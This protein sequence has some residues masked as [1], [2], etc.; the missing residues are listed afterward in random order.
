MTQSPTMPETI[1]ITAATMRDDN[2]DVART[3]K[4][5]GYA[6][7]I[8]PGVVPPTPEELHG[9][10]HDAVGVIA[11]S[12]TYSR[13]VM[14]AAPGLRVISRNGV[15]YDAVDLDAATDLGIVVAYVPDA[16]V[17][18][19]ADLTLGLLLAAA[20]RITMLDAGMK[21][22][23][24]RRQIAADV[25][26]TT[27][28]IVGTGRIGLAV[29]RRAQAFG[30][31]LLG[32]D[33]YPNP[34]FTEEFG[35]EYLPLDQLLEQSDYVSLHMPVLPETRGLMDAPRLARMKPSAYL[36]NAAR[37]ALVDEAA[38]LQALEAGKLAGAALDVF[39]TEPPLPDSPA[40]KLARHPNVVATPHVASY[41]PVTAARMGQ[42]AMEN[43]LTALG[44]ERPAY[45]ANPDVYSRRL[46][47]R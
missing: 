27:L 31:R 22:G 23:E 29:A 1:A 44:G 40:A 12:D 3:L 30:M 4:S 19:V 46:R 8:H 39:S 9:Y 11:G 36:I 21:A 32:H 26:G 38:L 24:W 37:G 45:V 15:G 6:L 47:G 14:E 28:G 7:K 17:D 25:N 33:P 18:S 42:G 34:R 43:L 2:N 5:A 35:G 41:T 10:L 20:R 16:M 13:A